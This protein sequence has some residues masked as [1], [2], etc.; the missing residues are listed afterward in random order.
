M[1]LKLVHLSMPQSSN[2]T[3]GLAAIMVQHKS[4]LLW[5]TSRYIQNGNESN[6]STAK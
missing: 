4:V 6:W 1:F 2:N 3:A 5:K